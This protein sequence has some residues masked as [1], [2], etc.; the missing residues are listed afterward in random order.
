MQIGTVC[1]NLIKSG[2]RLRKVPTQGA[3]AE[4]QTSWHVECSSVRVGKRT[5][6]TSQ[7][8]RYRLRSIRLSA[9]SWSHE[10]GDLHDSHTNNVL[11]KVSAR[12]TSSTFL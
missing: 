9:R 1:I 8:H 6:C 2:Y 4:I 11:A 10:N 7:F 5:Y 12:S 3:L